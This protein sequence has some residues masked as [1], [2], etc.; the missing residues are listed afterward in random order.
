MS[1]GGP[2]EPGY[3][4][5]VDGVLTAAS[6]VV[7][8]GDVVYLTEGLDIAWMSGSVEGGLG[9]R[10]EELVGQPAVNLV[11]PNQDRSWVDANRHQL[12]AGR[13]VA[14]RLLIRRKDGG[15]RWFSGVAHPVSGPSGTSGFVVVLH[16]LDAKGAQGSGRD[17]VTGVESRQ[18]IL[19]MLEHSRADTDGMCVLVVEFE[20]LRVVNESLGHAAGDEALATF[21]RRMRESLTGGERIGRVSGKSFLVGCMHDAPVDDLAS[22]AAQLIESW[23][24]E[25]L[26]GGRRIEPDLVAALVPLP[27]GSSSLTV[28]QDSDVA[29]SYARRSGER[30]TVFEQ[31]MSDET[32]RRFVIEDELRF[33]VDADEFE[34][35]FQPVVA[36]ADRSPVGAEALVRWRH[37]RE[38]LLTPASFLPIAEE[39]RLIRPMGRRLLARG[40]D[41]L[42]RL[43]AHSL[44]VGVNVSAVEL[45]D[46]SWLAGVNEI[47][48]SA[49]VDPCCLVL[50]ITET[51]VLSARR[52]LASDLGALKSRGVGVFLDD[53]GTGYSSLSMLR[54]LPVSGLKLDK[55]F[56]SS[57]DDEDSFG[58]A[59]SQGIL[60][61]IRPLGLAGVAEGI[62]TER[63]ATR[64][65]EIGWEF[66]QGYLFGRPGPFT[67]LPV[68]A[69]PRDAPRH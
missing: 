8:P 31:G 26:V 54:D 34:L 59:L 40:L 4:S 42:S 24:A 67:E 37:P 19:D 22:R 60:D 10:P 57:L 33:A 47:L 64:L 29:L 58:A 56:V 2:E 41:A 27:A 13:D 6:V 36:L 62:E 17:P 28:M 52:N 32:L 11:S 46:E 43:P 68:P 25:M 16:P 49:D 35:H 14:Q 66:G 7:D 65:R 1:P 55:S 45:A 30:V 23:S 18:Q 39:S 50:E 63:Q 3:A 9:W 5:L 15:E 12:I 61:L 20:N 69:G 38:G 53:F 21:A 44:Q 51:A 48:D